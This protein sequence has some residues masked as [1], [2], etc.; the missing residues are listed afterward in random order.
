MPGNIRLRKGEGNLPRP[1]VVNVTQIR[2]VD[3]DRLV[4]H[5]GTLGPDRLR[6]V[7]RGMAL[8]FGIYQRHLD[9][10]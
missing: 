2:T 9:E 6:E 10:G 5:V 3:R 8:V 1:S 7:L 4:E